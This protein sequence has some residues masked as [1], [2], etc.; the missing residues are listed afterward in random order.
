MAGMALRSRLLPSYR[1]RSM[2]IGAASTRKVSD[3]AVFFPPHTQVFAAR[4]HASRPAFCKP[5]AVLSRL[6]S[7]EPFQALRSR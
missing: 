6:A 2:I 7:R 4:L 3:L 1:Q 5:D